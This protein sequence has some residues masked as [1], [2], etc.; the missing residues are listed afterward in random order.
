MGLETQGSDPWAFFGG[1]RCRNVWVGV[2]GWGL[3]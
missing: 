2:F 1:E 3:E